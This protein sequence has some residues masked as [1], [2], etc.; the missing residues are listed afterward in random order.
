MTTPI[1]DFVRNYAAKKTLRLHMPGHKGNSILGIEALDI[2]EI[3]GAD[4]LYDAKGIIKQS[5]DNAAKVFGSA[6]TVY[7]TEGSSLS[8]RAMLYL[9]KIYGN[10]KNK[11]PLI[12]AGRNA[13]KTFVT[14]AALMDFEI[15]WL[16][17]S[18][19]DT[20]ISCNITPRFLEE[21]FK[22][23]TE[24]PLAV[25]VTSPDYLGNTLDI[26]ALSEVCKK[27]NSLLL[28][29]NAHGAYLSFLPK[30]LHPIAQ[31]AD[32]S[33]DSAHKTLPVLTGGAYLHISGNAPKMFL[34]QAENAMSV[35]ASTSP[36]YL[37]LQSL[38]MANKYLSEG[39]R[40][41][42]CSFT[43]K[44]E[45]LKKELK[46][47]GY[48]LYG[49]EPLKLTVA[50]K[51][52]GY[53][54]CELAEIL[55]AKGIVCEFADPDFVVMMLSCDMGEK[56]LTLLR[57]ALSG[58][59]KKSE[60]T[61]NP[62]RLRAYKK[63]M[64]LKKAIFSSNEE[65]PVKDCCGRILATASVNC[66]PAIPIVVCGEEITDEAIECFEYYGIK[67]CLVVTEIK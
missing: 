45:Q 59:E 46:E 63:R 1:V 16:L 54:G 35:F 66:P 14:A 7:S 6:K 57:K 21:Y 29:D 52:F 37:I 43:E 31:G 5:E 2:T 15:D 24:K 10:T 28:V 8:I 11:S 44:T 56:G 53:T 32:I 58:I 34:N 13:H 61:A 60:I 50:P 36:S 30:N 20:L 47:I 27:Y 25:Y 17:P 3:E 67:S 64:S 51:S 26:A 18:N 12:S 48:K 41:R 38:D 40:E 19:A 4:V 55:E 22:N 49:N 33:C 65:L 9:T 62:P 23:S 39:Y 42:L